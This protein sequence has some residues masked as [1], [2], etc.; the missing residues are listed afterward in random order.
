MKGTSP[1]WLL[2]WF[3]SLL[4][5]GCGNSDDPPQKE[6]VCSEGCGPNQTCSEGACVCLT[7]F[8]D[9]DG[10][11]SNGC[12]IA[13]TQCEAGCTP[14]GDQAFCDRHGKECGSFAGRDNCG[15]SRTV[16]CGSCT[17]GATCGLRTPNVCGK[18]EECVGET[19]AELC[20]FLGKDCGALETDD[21]CD[22]R[23]TVEC[24]SCPEGDVCGL[25]QPNVCGTPEVC[26]PETDEALCERLG[27]NCGTISATDNCGDART[28]S[29]G[30][31][32]GEE[33]CGEKEP[34]VCARP[35]APCEPESDTSFCEGNKKNCG[36][37]SGIDNCGQ[38]RTADCGECGEGET[39][40]SVEAFVCG[41]TPC[42]PE[43]DQVL[44]QAEGKNCGTITA[45]DR[46]G[47][48][49]SIDCGRCLSGQICGAVEPNVCGRDTSCVPEDDASLC[50][51]MGM[52]CGTV[53]AP[54]NCGNFRTVTCGTC[55]EGYICGLEQPNVCKSCEE[56]DEEFCFNKGKTCGNFTGVD[57]CGNTRSVQCG[58]CGPGTYCL[59]NSCEPT[60]GAPAYNESCMPTPGNFINCA[61]GLSCIV[62]SNANPLFSG[63]KVIC[64]SD[65]QCMFG[66]CVPGVLGS[67]EGLCGN[68]LSVGE[69]CGDLFET[70]DICHPVA[71]HSCV[72][73]ICEAD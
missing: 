58:G 63:C 6:P 37:F 65:S 53:N 52:D 67:G 49:R 45:T 8:L 7:G 61:T 72:N 36:S 35:D 68:S 29:C 70:P 27:K 28:P 46:C 11:A 38:A 73:G 62:N 17:D 12:E 25:N 40:G 16:D 55:E 48:T 1:R 5:W 32:A 23:R 4:L 18:Q 20:T 47:G 59:A 69:S 50:A 3:A 30:S 21:R 13:G 22:E 66:T 9:C 44:C 57:L 10:V 56:T 31:C 24:G 51:S 15:E 43:V 41:P 26:E 64:S 39:C 60:G 71:T 34:N 33:V 42:Q 54:D 14:E 2:L 19:D